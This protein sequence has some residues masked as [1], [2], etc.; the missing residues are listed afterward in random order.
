M[1][2]RLISTE[3]IVAEFRRLVKAR[4]MK[5][6]ADCTMLLKY[7][8]KLYLK[9]KKRSCGSVQRW[10]Q[11]FLHESAAKSFQNLI[12]KR[13]ALLGRL[14][15]C[16]KEIYHW[17]ILALTTWP[18]VCFSFSKLVFCA[19]YKLHILSV[20][21][22]LRYVGQVKDFSCI[23]IY[24][25]GRFQLVKIKKKKAQLDLKQLLVKK[26]KFTTITS[27]ILNIF[28]HEFYLTRENNFFFQSCPF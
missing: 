16:F 15:S 12:R 2:I 6:V 27:F 4:P 22:D 17:V 1:W 19:N 8:T 5:K 20:S 9:E 18:I 3:N 25:S 28:S 26:I 10:G 11:N 13:S 14:L 21:V 7:F 23:Q 24:V